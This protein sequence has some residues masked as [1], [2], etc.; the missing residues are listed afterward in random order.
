M[1]T[2]YPGNSESGY[3]ATPPDDDGTVSEANKVKWSTIKTKLSDPVKTLAEAIET[4]LVAHF[5]RGPVASA[6]TLTVAASNYNELLELTS[7]ENVILPDASGIGTGFFVDLVNQGSSAR[8]IA[9]TTSTDTINGV[10]A[11]ATIPPYSSMRIALNVA[12]NGYDTVFDNKLTTRGDIMYINSSSQLDRLAVGS[13]NQFLKSDGTDLSW[14]GI[15]NGDIE[16]GDLP[17]GSIPVEGTEAAMTTS[18]AVTIDGSVPSWVQK[19]HINLAGVSTNG[20]SPPMIQLGDSGGF[21]TSG[22]AGSVGHDAGAAA[23]STGFHLTDTNFA[24]ATVLE[25][26]IVLSLEDSANNTWCCNIS[27][28]KSDSAVYFCGGGSK[29][30]SGVLTQIRITT[31]GGTDTFDAGAINVMYS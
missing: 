13:A 20:S 24:A 6:A 5:D 4:D 17:T 12:E 28:G 14:G 16:L 10:T 30:L 18:T 8:T 23:M 2:K 7:S 25:G 21:E 26:T 22:Y 15:A 3:N 31:V 11:N 19:I 9:R 29:S 27:L 1:G